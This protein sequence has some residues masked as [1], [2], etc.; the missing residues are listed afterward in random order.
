[1]LEDTI[2]AIATAPGESAIGI[3][4]LSGPQAIAIGDKI[5]A[6]K[7][8]RSLA[9]AKSHT[10]QFG[11]IVRSG[12][13]VDQAVV[14]VFCAPHSYT[15]EDV[16]EISLHG[17]PMILRQVVSLC[18]SQGAR[19]AQP[20]EFTQRAYC[21]GKMDL[22][23][24]EAVAHLIRA[25]T[26]KARLSAME[27]LE[28]K[29][30]HFIESLRLQIVSTLAHLEV[31]LDHSDDDQPFLS[32]QQLQQKLVQIKAR[33]Q[34]LQ[35]TFR[36]GAFLREG[37]KVVIVGKPNV[38]KSSLLNCLLRQD[39]ALVTEIPGTTRDTLQEAMDLEGIPLML[40]DTAGLR[41]KTTDTV[42]RL[43]IERTKKAL[44]QAQVILSVFDAASIL[45]PEDHEVF[46]LVKDQMAK[47]AKAIVVLNKRD[48]P[49]ILKSEQ[50]LDLTDGLRE[51]V[52]S[53]STLTGEGLKDLEGTLKK[54]AWQETSCETVLLSARHHE[55]LV[56]A[57]AS[58]ARAQQTP[59]DQP[60]IIA[61]E[62]RG[63]L[64]SLGKIVGETATED[65]LA[66]IFSHFCIG[67]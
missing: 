28:G 40:S 34:E 19:A 60:E 59:Q 67:K 27:H 51:R 20:G 58:L 65:I 53:T 48:L 49:A 5:F 6:S 25:K 56:E 43:G 39:R 1:M 9:G 50:F 52:V 31:G 8:G 24:A 3:V 7:S 41:D 22:A 2:V 17:N 47:G 45:S 37:L 64:D 23:Q 57:R 35:E 55:A 11:R 32:H 66:E 62:L 44:Q 10:L 26:E 33:L 18:L 4:R 54:I 30:S 16:I 12:T 29:L 14:S 46:G 21:H 61:L 38:G 42:E 36:S 13:A 15:G 63:A